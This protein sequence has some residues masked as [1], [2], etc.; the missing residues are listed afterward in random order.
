M[1]GDLRGVEDPEH[2][3]I[4]FVRSCLTSSPTILHVHIAGSGA[5]VHQVLSRC[6]RRINEGSGAAVHQVLSRCFGRINEGN[7][8]E[9]C[10]AIYG[11][12]KIQNMFSSSLSG[13][14]AA[15]HQV[16][17]R[18]FGRINEGNKVERCSA[19]YGAR[20]IQNMFSSSL[21]GKT[22]GTEFHN[23][24]TSYR[25]GRQKRKFAREFIIKLVDSTSPLLRAVLT[26]PGG[27]CREVIMYKSDCLSAARSC[28]TRGSWTDSNTRP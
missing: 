1:L 7:K 27:T 9:R 8:V 20:K 3:F 19:I 17:S 13:S 25:T 18:C 16:L 5:A 10:S 4:V 2:V 22:R 23:S 21:S 28:D 14:G 24:A 15:V 6:F 11:A 12:R 26:A